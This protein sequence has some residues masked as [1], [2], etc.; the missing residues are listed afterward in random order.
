MKSIVALLNLGAAC[1]SFTAAYSSRKLQRTNLIAPTPSSE[2]ENEAKLLIRTVFFSG[3]AHNYRGCEFPALI[4][5][6]ADQL[7]DG[8]N[9][10]CFTSVDLVNVCVLI[11]YA[12]S[13][14][15]NNSRLTSQGSRKWMKQFMLSRRSIQ[16]QLPLPNSWMERGRGGKFEGSYLGHLQGIEVSYWYWYRSFLTLL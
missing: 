14:V 4:D 5:A 9:T 11:P 7:Q 3:E 13:R 6:T 2:R 16:M 12:V 8:L 1:L 15:T 10:G